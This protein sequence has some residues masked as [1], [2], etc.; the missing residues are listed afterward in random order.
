MIGPRPR[1]DG[2]PTIGLPVPARVLA[3]D[4]HPDDVEFG[5]GATLAKWARAGAEVHLLVLTDGSKGT[6]DP[7]AD[8]IALAAERTAEQEAARVALGAVAIHH[9]GAVDGELHE[10]PELRE[11]V[12]AV[13]RATCPDVL[14]THDPWRPYRLHPDH[15]HGGFLVLDAVVAA[16]DPHFFPGQDDPPHRPEV[17]LL[18]EPGEVHHLEPVGPDDLAAREAALLAHRSQWRSTMGIDGPDDDAGRR[19][20][21]ER[22]RAG[23]AAFG[24]P[25]GLTAAEGFARIAEV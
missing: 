14:L 13:I 5:C 23:S 22:L 1:P 18:F 11:Q 7:T 3:V 25:A 12:C 9:L 15:R 21:V 20:F 10:G 6:W 16:R 4:A 2:A 17:V 8:P 19:T 24:A